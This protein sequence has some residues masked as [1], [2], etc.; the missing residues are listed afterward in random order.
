MATKKDLPKSVTDV[1]PWFKDYD[2]EKI[3]LFSLRFYDGPLSGV[4]K[5]KDKHYYAEAF[6]EDSRGIWIAYELTDQERDDLLA[7]HKSFQDNVGTHT[8]YVENKLG[9]YVRC[10]GEGLKPREMWD[11]HY[12]NYVRKSK[13]EIGPDREIAGWFYNIF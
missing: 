6:H 11:N 4:F 1:I 7:D 2:E 3:P 9:D 13:L 8:D 10:I 5:L 12:K